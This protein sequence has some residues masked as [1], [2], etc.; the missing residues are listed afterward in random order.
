MAAL[1][2]YF[3]GHRDEIESEL[4]AERIRLSRRQALRGIV[5]EAI[6]IV[7]LFLLLKNF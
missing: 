6:L 2:S 3:M 1:K 5:V 4:R 7:C